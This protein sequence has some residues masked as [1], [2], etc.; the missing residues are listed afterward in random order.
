MDCAEVESLCAYKWFKLKTIRNIW[1]VCVSTIP[2]LYAV[3]ASVR[4]RLFSHYT[5]PWCSFLCFIPPG[6]SIRWPNR[7][8]YTIS[9]A[10]HCYGL[11]CVDVEWVSEW[12]NECHKTHKTFYNVESATKF[13]L[14]TELMSLFLRCSFQWLKNARVC[15][16]LLFFGHIVHTYIHITYTYIHFFIVLYLYLI[17][18]FSKHM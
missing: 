7:Q 18:S 5:W 9:N 3:H 11:W 12:V 16:L 1:C 17:V 15:F 6:F 8:I 10:S 13:I 4:N 2:W 14:T